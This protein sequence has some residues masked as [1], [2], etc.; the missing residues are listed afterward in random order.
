LFAYTV[1]D[2]AGEENE[3]N[4]MRTL[5]PP[6]RM[7]SVNPEPFFDRM[8]SS[9]D[10]HPQ[11]SLGEFYTAWDA[12]RPHNGIYLIYGDHC[13]T[14]LAQRILQ[15]PLLARNSIL[16]IDGCNDFSVSLYA[17]MAQRFARPTEE[18]LRSIRMSRALTGRQMVALAERVLQVTEKHKASLVVVLGPLAA[19]CDERVSQRETDELFKQFQGALR[20]LA[21]SGLRLLLACPEATAKNRPQYLEALKQEAVFRLAC[22]RCGESRVLLH[23]EHPEEVRQ[24]WAL[25]PSFGM[26]VRYSRQMKLF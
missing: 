18:Y 10:L 12:V 11:F 21:Q 17:R 3:V 20:R 25:A 22:E 26:S 6:G 14:E 24:T 16:I 5:P 2:L 4:S 13:A 8:T 15:R 7:P 19:F 1:C 23:L 9:E